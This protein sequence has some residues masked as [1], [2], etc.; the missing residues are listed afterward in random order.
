M[1]SLNKL[2]ILNKNDCQNRFCYPL[3]LTY[4]KTCLSPMGD[5]QQ[6]LKMSHKMLTTWQNREIEINLA[7]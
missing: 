4:T 1:G 6:A 3:R 2:S 5:K 7:P